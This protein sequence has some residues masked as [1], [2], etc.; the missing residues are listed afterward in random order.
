MVYLRL[1]TFL[2]LLFCVA[3]YYLLLLTTTYCYF[4]LLTTTYYYLLLLT[5]T[6]YYL[7]LLTTIYYCFY[8]YNT[9]HKA[10]VFNV[11]EL[12]GHG[13]RTVSCSTTK[14][15][16]KSGPLP[17]TVRAREWFAGCHDVP[18][19]FGKSGCGTCVNCWH[20][21]F[22]CQ[23]NSGVSLMMNLRWLRY[24]FRCRTLS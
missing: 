2:L 5:T 20:T 1:T 10:T 16:L 18:H 6:Y 23:S 12:A 19:N 15:A 3:F 24:S 22:F 8:Y 9:F 13:K 14:Y 21:V 11:C 17:C 4:L 7:L